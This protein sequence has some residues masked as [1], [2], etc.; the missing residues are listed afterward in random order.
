MD[1]DIDFLEDTSLQ[2]QSALERQV[3][4]LTRLNDQLKRSK[5]IQ[6]TLLAISNIATK[7]NSLEHFYQDVHQ[8]L[9]NIIPADNFFVANKKPETNFITLPFFYDQQDSHPS[10]L[11]PDQTISELLNKG[12]TGYA[13]KTEQTLHCDRAKYDEYIKQGR[14]KDLGSPCHQWLGVPIKNNNGTRGLLVVQTYDE[15]ITYG[16]LEVELLEFISQ[17]ISGVMERLQHQQQLEIA[18]EE[19]TREL[20]NAYHNLK[21]EVKVRE[22][23]EQLQKSLF[24]IADL[25]A[26]VTEE[27]HFYTKLHH[28]LSDLIPAQNCFIALK[29]GNQ[30]TFPFYKSQLNSSRPEPRAMED[31]LT[32]FIMANKKPALITN[33]EIQRLV[34]QKKIYTHTPELNRTQSMHQWI[35]IPLI[36][37][38]EV[39]GAL[40]LYSLEEK[41]QYKAKDV[42]FL[43][44]VSQHIANAIARKNAVA[45]LQ[46]SHEELEEQVVKR[47]RAL[48]A[49]N[50]QLQSEIEQ[51]RNIEAQLVHDALHDGLTGLPNRNLLMDQLNQAIKNHRRLNLDP[52]ALLFIDLD[53]F[54]LINDTLGHQQG[55]HFLI[56]TAK[57]LKSCI[58]QHDTL[59]RMGGDEFVI[60]LSAINGLND[61]KEVA[62]RILPTLAEPYILAKQA[63]TSGAS[64]GISYIDQHKTATSETLLREADAAMYQAKA[65]GKGCY[66]VFDD[67]LE[68]RTESKH[69]Q[70]KAFKTA[71]DQQK[72]E[73][74]FEEVIDI[75]S[76]NIVAIEPRVKW[77]QGAEESFNHA[78]MSNLAEQYQL[79]L[80]LDAYV[81]AHINAVY[82]CLKQRYGADTMLH[83]PVSSRHLKNKYTMRN[84]KNTLTQSKIDPAKIQLFFAEKGLVKDIESHINA[85]KII[86]DHGIK[87]GINGYGIGYSAL[88]N[89]SFLPLTSLKLDDSV[90]QV[91][92]NSQQKSLLKSYLL[93]AT[94]LGLEVFTAGIDLQEQKKQLINLGF[95]LGQGK[96][97]QSS[98]SQCERC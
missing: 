82:P 80:H 77:T 5:L 98:T 67:S 87:V 56:E 46:R 54:K 31:G 2:Q 44:F 69:L 94:A 4:H 13:F 58:R 30:L 12:I 33:Q 72:I 28:I 15:A 35:G 75:V 19:R 51:R 71:L 38:A 17:H 53:R 27:N 79:T 73:V 40:T 89:I 21:L 61:A 85:F 95:T 26:T 25:S 83:M 1:K 62:E 68:Q 7:A 3:T 42:E 29:S 20:S 47:T 88:A 16:D 70:E 66:V 92:T 52:F 84:L 37:D 55:D 59:A 39:I 10:D 97:C 48:K 64:I 57:R 60:L 93:S 24:E 8:Y 65:N 49:S 45:S 50:T 43:T 41:H 74:Y 22:T 76:N 34:E 36:I 9:R 32:E 86:T 63:F 78:Q 11:Y 96:L 6:D 18:I 14:F 90:C 91:T 81:F 23:A